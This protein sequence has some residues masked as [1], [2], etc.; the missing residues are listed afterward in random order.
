MKKNF[1]IKLVIQF[2]VFVSILLIISGMVFYNYS[3]SIMKKNA[4]SNQFNT[5]IK[6]QEQLERVLYEMDRMSIAINASPYIMGILKDIPED[7]E[8]NFFDYNPT[9]SSMIKEQMYSI[10]SLTNQNVRFKLITK[11]YDV[12][13]I[14][15]QYDIKQTKE[16]IMQSLPYEEMMASEV[17]RFIIPPY[18]NTSY[19]YNSQVISIVRPIRDN[20][21]NV[22]GVVQLDL[23]ITQLEALTEGLNV[24]ILDESKQLV[25]SNSPLNEE[26]VSLLE[27]ST[28]NED[29]GI[30]N[31]ESKEMI[32]SYSKMDSYELNIV[33]VTM[34]EAFI[35]PMNNLGRLVLVTYL[36]VFLLLMILV[37]VYI[38]LVTKPIRDLTDI[39]RQVDTSN[40]NIEL[41]VD[42]VEGDLESLVDSFQNLILAVQ[43]SSQEVVEM[44]SREMDTKIKALEA[45][46]NPHF[47][48]NT[49][50][51]I[52]GYGMKSGNETV[53]K[54]CLDLSNML[55]Y[56][57]DFSQQ[58]ATLETELDHVE[59]Y[60]SLMKRRFG[61]LFD[62]DIEVE[63][64]ITN[65]TVPKLI[66]QPIVENSFTHGFLTSSHIWHITIKVCCDGQRWACTISDNGDGFK[67]PDI[68]RMYE[69]IK[70]MKDIGDKSGI[71]LM[72][73]IFRLN[74]YYKDKEEIQVY[75][76][77][78]AVISLKGPVDYERN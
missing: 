70:M 52:G 34:Y 49:L 17:Y 32:I 28:Y 11:D 29:E 55:R 44:K 37:Y 69:Q 62:Y 26:Q 7:Q 68:T 58:Y 19:S 10:S 67:D 12:T 78:G 6:V 14:S 76:K 71:G 4:A 18:S 30:V 56:T 43:A 39:V 16:E 45:Q 57:V 65:I 38:K 36:A 21:D 77:K 53:Y 48:Y 51:V 59:T 13:G 22:Y 73:T 41:Q 1:Q 25:Y 63:N 24:V 15:T 20:Y 66:L 42:A 47:I 9:I 60:L 61:E 8:D 40:Q 35:K 33:Q 50:S 3:I 72:N 23:P 54:M 46:L 27:A 2:S 74:H 31:D 75:N 5:T 64:P